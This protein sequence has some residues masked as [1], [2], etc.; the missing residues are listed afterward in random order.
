VTVFVQTEPPVRFVKE[1]RDLV[2]DVRDKAEFSCEVSDPK[3]K[4]TWYR[5]DTE[6]RSRLL[7]YYGA[8]QFSFVILAFV[9]LSECYLWSVAPIS[10]CW[11]RGPRGCF[12]RECC[13]DGTSMAALFP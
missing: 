8:V 4:V 9:F 2:V 10:A 1:M 12:R 13:T 11:R 5:N 3:A 6:V 7:S